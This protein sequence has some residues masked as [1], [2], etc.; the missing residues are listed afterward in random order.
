MTNFYSIQFLVFLLSSLLCYYTV[1]RKKQW[2]C[3]LIASAV[4][5]AFTGME[6]FVFLLLTGFSTWA[7]ARWINKRSVELKQI[8]KDKMI[9]RAEKDLRKG[10]VVRKRRIMMWGV[11]LLNFGLLAYIKFPENILGLVLPLG[12]SFYMFQSIGYLLD[13][14]NEKYEPEADFARYMLFVSY[15]P[16]MIQGPIN[17]YDAIGGQFMQEHTW[18]GEAATK[19]GYRIFYGLF[20][21]YAIANIFIGMIASVFDNPVKDYAGCTVLFAILLY[22]AQ[23]YA[24]FSGGID[25]VLGVS[26]LFGI[27]MAENFKQPYFAT[28]LGDFWRR[29]HISLGKWMR[30][31]VFYPFALTKP[32]KKLGKWV[33]KRFGKHLGRVLPPAIGNLLVFFV[34]GIWHGTKW[35]YVIWGLY[36]GFVIAFSDILA[37]VFDKVVE[38]L[39]INRKARWYH[40]F[41]IV[42]T[43]I[44]VNIGWYFDRIEDIKV[45]L[46]SLKKTLLDFNMAL[47]KSE[48]MIITHDYADYVIPLAVVACIFVFI[49][50]VLEERKVDVRV[51]LYSK[52]L[53]VRWAL[54]FF[55]IGM[56]LVASI[57]VSGTG[58]FMY[59]NF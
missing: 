10:Q 24:D 44:I 7:G 52:S 4:F 57:S 35:H 8:K 20:K 25:M 18:N 2:V 14:Y 39:H 54:Y 40:V 50:S 34:V 1:F 32:V 21:K 17:R 26:E 38:V 15:F 12:I 5:Y 6:N 27:Q 31:Y 51:A 55:V 28:S 16:Q 53:L 33:N 46:Y 11:V 23:Q 41:A 56:I 47:F 13:I 9:E 48:W 3:L 37:P 36:N 43:F 49:V 45:A 59:A 58:G 29:W 30:D 22:S 42:R 19:A